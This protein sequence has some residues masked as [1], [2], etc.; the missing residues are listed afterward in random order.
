MS[1]GLERNRHVMRVD[2]GLHVELYDGPLH[3]ERFTGA[4]A[5]L[6]RESGAPYKYDD[7]A[8]DEVAAGV[9]EG[10]RIRVPWWVGRLW[11]KFSPFDAVRFMRLLLA[12]PELRDAAL[13]VLDL[14]RGRAAADLAAFLG[15]HAQGPGA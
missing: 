2:G 3:P 5:Q 1:G 13:T 10:A 8:R 6:I 9:P 14:S 15:A 4:N 12:D 11:V 7:R